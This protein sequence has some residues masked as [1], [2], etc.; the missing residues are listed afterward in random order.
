M[1]KLVLQDMMARFYV[2]GSTFDPDPNIHS[3][4]EGQRE[5]VLH[6]LS[7]LNYD[8][9]ALLAEIEDANKEESEEA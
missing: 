5:A 8:E 7:L 6:I 9:R 1:G 3:H 2:A 4:K